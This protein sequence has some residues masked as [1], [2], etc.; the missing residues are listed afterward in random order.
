MFIDDTG[1]DICQIEAIYN[2][3]WGIN[4]AVMELLFDLEFGTF[5]EA[6]AAVDALG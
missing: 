2:P 5:D 3:F 4:A 6:R 1:R